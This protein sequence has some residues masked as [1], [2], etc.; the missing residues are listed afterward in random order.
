MIWDLQKQPCEDVVNRRAEAAVVHNLDLRF[1]KTRHL[2]SLFALLGSFALLLR[3]LV[4]QEQIGIVRLA[5]ASNFARS[6]QKVAQVQL[7]LAQI[8]RV[9]AQARDELIDVCSVSADDKSA[10]PDKNAPT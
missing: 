4:F 8:A 5:T 3:L 7:E 10:V 6:D 1:Q 9:L 2:G